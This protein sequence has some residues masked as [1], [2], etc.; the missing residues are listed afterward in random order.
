MHYKHSENAIAPEEAFDCVKCDKTFSSVAF[1]VQVVLVIGALNSKQL[2]PN[3]FTAWL[4]HRPGEERTGSVPL[5][6]VKIISSPSGSLGSSWSNW[7]LE[8]D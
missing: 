3:I 6:L 7:V 1:R 8:R 2:L 4:I 5:L